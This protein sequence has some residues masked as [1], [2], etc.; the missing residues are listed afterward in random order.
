[1]I[2]ERGDYERALGLPDWT[3][4][5]FVKKIHLP[6]EAFESEEETVD[7]AL[8]HEYVHA[9]LRERTRRHI[10]S[11]LGEG[12]A[13]LLADARNPEGSLT[14][15]LRQTESP[16]DL[17]IL[18]SDFADLMGEDA[19]WAYLQ[20]YWITHDLIEEHGWPSMATLIRDLRE[21]RH[22]D[23]DAVFASVYGASPAEYLERC[24]ERAVAVD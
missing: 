3:G 17:E 7:R 18:S 22:E 15:L 11:W 9:L 2:Y 1:V 14:E 16:P 19:H 20:S 21:R 23:F 24:Y 8:G 4:G 6:L 5:A 13:N 12:L 10:P